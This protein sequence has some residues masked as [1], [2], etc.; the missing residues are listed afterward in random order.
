M[1]FFGNHP[2]F[3][4]GTTEPTR[5]LLEEKFQEVVKKAG[6]L[7]S[8]TE[9]QLVTGGAAMS[10]KWNGTERTLDKEIPIE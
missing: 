2:M 3:F 6:H 8:A 10:G 4:F 5:K 1:Q 9:Q 7:A